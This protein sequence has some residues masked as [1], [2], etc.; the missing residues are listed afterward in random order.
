[1]DFNQGV[2]DGKQHLKVR[3]RFC[4]RDAPRNAG[5]SIFNP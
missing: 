3:G 2:N 1:M 5:V 4:Q